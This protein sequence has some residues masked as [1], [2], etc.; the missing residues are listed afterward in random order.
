[1]TSRN[2][3]AWRDTII[4]S[5][6][7]AVCYQFLISTIPLYT[8]LS[9]NALKM[10][11]V[12]DGVIW[13]ILRWRNISVWKHVAIGLTA[14]IAPSFI[15]PV[16]GIACGGLSLTL[17][18]GQASEEDEPK[19]IA[20]RGKKADTVA[21]REEYR[22]QM[23]LDDPGFFWACTLLPIDMATRNMLVIGTVGSGKTLTINM[24]MR[25]VLPLL[26]PGSQRR[27]IVFD[28]KQ[29]VYPIIRGI[30]PFCP[31][32]ILNPMDQRCTAW[33]MAR[34]ITDPLGGPGHG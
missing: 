1:M 2:Q 19:E 27:A 8:F 33:D 18:T 5:I 4:I 24:F 16:A 31:I 28:P 11:L 25:S 15:H 26:V 30:G 9:F 12:L 6:L 20:L 17:L 22:Q 7:L 13:I 3:D 23:N 34:D 29:E 32:Y 21:P 14:V 10:V